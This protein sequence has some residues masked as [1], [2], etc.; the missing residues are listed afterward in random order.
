MEGIP[1]TRSAVH[2]YGEQD[3][4]TIYILTYTKNISVILFIPRM[5]NQVLDPTNLIDTKM[6]NLKNWLIVDGLVSLN[7]RPFEF[8]NTKMVTF[9]DWLMV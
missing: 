2:S 9:K 5:I 1:G 7:T 8:M 6:V 3:R 4:T